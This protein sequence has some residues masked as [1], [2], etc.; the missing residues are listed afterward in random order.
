LPPDQSFYFRGPE[1]KLHLR[2]QNLFSFIELGQGVDDATWLHH[3]HRG[4]YSAWI[5]AMIKDQSLAAA[6]AEVESMSHVSAA[7]SRA[8]L[9]AAIEDR[10][11]LPASVAKPGAG[12]S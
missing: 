3:L 9:K 5:G 4:D 2:A 7:E 1:G 10:Y 6:V 11:T 8:L 12:S